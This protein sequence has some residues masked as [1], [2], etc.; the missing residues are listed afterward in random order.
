MHTLGLSPEKLDEFLHKNTIKKSGELYNKV[1][2]RKLAAILPVHVFGHPCKI[3][4]I[5]KINEK[6]GISVIED[7]AEAIGS[8]YK[9]QHVGRFGL[10]GVLSFNGNK[11]ITAGGGGAI[12]TANENLAKR[13]K[14]LTTTAKIKHKWEYYHDEVGY[15]YRMPNINAAVLLA[16]L[17]CLDSFLAKKRKLTL[18]YK[19]FFEKLGIEFLLE[20][21]NA[22]SNYW[23]N[24]I[25]LANRKERDSFLEYANSNNVM[26]RPCWVLMNKLPMYKDCLAVDIRNAL[27]IE[28]RLVNIPSGVIER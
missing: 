1:S 2:G 12:I 21:E 20:P 7:A 4:E 27:Y 5:V 17:E 9:H 6:F 23:L 14:H 10:M 24:A 19:D 26:A 8:Y 28:E 3:D 11:I 25:F 16:Q 18:A 15:N 22:K 13:A